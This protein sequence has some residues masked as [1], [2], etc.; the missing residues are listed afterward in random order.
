MTECR[1]PDERDLTHRK[2][3]R[4]V[5]WQVPAVV[6]LAGIVVNS[7][8]RTI[9]WTGALAVAGAACVANVSRS[10]RLHCYVTGPFYL[11]AAAVTLTYGLGVLSLGP[12]GWGWIGL[13]VAAGSGIL[14]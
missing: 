14:V 2:F 4:F 6:L 10:G 1:A 9:L 11:L 3:A 12:N 5:L 13:G 7:T 8:W